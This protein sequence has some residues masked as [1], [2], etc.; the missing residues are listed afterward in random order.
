VS[1]SGSGVAAIVPITVNYVEPPAIATTT[2][3]TFTTSGSTFKTSKRLEILEISTVGADTKFT[4]SYYNS[5]SATKYNVKDIT[6]TG[7]WTYQVGTKDTLSCTLV[8]DGASGYTLLQFDSAANTLQAVANTPFGTNAALVTGNKVVLK[9]NCAAAYL[10]GTL[11]QIS[12]VTALTPITVPTGWVPITTTES[13]TWGVAAGALYKFNPTTKAYSLVYTFPTGTP[14]DAYSFKGAPGRL[15]VTAVKRISTTTPASGT[16]PVDVTQTFFVFAS[17]EGGNFTLLSQFSINATVTPAAGSLTTDANRYLIDFFVSPGFSKLVFTYMA[18]GAASGTVRTT[19]FKAIDW[20]R[21]TVSDLI[22]KDI[23]K[24]RQTCAKLAAS[25]ADFVLGDNFFVIRNQSAYDSSAPS[26]NAVEETYQFVSTNVNLVRN[27]VL[28]QTDRDT[29]FRIFIDPIFVNELM[30]VAIN[31]ISGGFSFSVS[32]Y[33]NF[34]AVTRIQPTASPAFIS[35]TIPAG[36]PTLSTPPNSL[37]WVY[38]KVTPA[39]AASGGNAAVAA[40]TAASYFRFTP[41][42][43]GNVISATET[44]T[45]SVNVLAIN[46]I[47]HIEKNVEASTYKV[48]YRLPS[49]AATPTLTIS[50]IDVTSLVSTLSLSVATWQIADN[51]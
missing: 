36:S 24:F 35:F 41:G 31:A 16:T 33:G 34:A 49:T 12:G 13:I 45:G 28:T 29:Y 37:G 51:C 30:V 48:V 21:R 1:V 43:T 40:S 27:R 25:N 20:S 3:G 22:V 38:K 17:P 39:T 26:I 23:T 18:Q 9:D 8:N 7:T 19:I 10:D 6:L 50:S 44:Q 42:V 15:I 2:P 4:Y 5:T 11:G 32:A 46:D 47:C 14:S